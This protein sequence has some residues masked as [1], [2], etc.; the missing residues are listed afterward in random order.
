MSV[1]DGAIG[2]MRTRADD[3]VCPCHW[4]WDTM[5]YY[6]F[7]QSFFREALGMILGDVH[8]H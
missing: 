4:S 6:Y 5:A 1:G 7:G 2:S 8:D 3:S